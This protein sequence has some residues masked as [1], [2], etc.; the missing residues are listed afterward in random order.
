[1]RTRFGYIFEAE[2]GYPAIC[3]PVALPPLGQAFAVDGPSGEI[4]VV[5]FDQ[6]HGGIRSVGFRFGDVAYSSDV[7]GLPEDAFA[8]LEGVDTW[9]VDA[10]R[11]T[12]HPTHAHVAMTLEWVARVK[13]RRT[14]LTNLHIDL[15]YAALS[16]RL[17]PTVE[18]AY[19]QMRFMVET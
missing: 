1:M 14:I 2:G 19:D 5:G 6:D 10:L 12:P 8:V 9:I 18:P 13:P 11:D 15:D 4:P 16:R 3:D 7:V 17:P